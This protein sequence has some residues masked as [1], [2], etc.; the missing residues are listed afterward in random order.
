MAK[1]KIRKMKQFAKIFELENQEQV[2]VLRDYNTT[3][4]EYYLIIRS[5]IAG[6]AFE[7]KMYFD[8]EAKQISAFKKFSKNDAIAMR[9]EF[10]KIYNKQ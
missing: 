2:L 6:I 3:I 7:T 4:D 1:N 10:I 5:D 9:R 8:E